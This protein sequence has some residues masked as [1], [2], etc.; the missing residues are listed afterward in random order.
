[1]TPTNVLLSYKTGIA[2]LG[3]F[4]FTRAVHD[5][6]PM[7]GMPCGRQNP[8]PFRAL[9]CT[10]LWYRAPELLFGAKHYGR[11]VDVWSYGCVLAELLGRQPLFPGRGEFDMLQKIIERRGTACEEV[12]KDCTALP[13]FLEF[14]FHPKAGRYYKVV[15]PCEAS[16]AEL[17]MLAKCGASSVSFLEE[18]LTLDP[19]QRP[20]TAQVGHL[21]AL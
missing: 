21:L 13:N 15:R 7:T 14:T 17:P 5:S 3:D 19:K 11:S 16:L 12:W 20:K 9:R 8:R 6:K 1:M 2:K 4:G 18:L 10:T